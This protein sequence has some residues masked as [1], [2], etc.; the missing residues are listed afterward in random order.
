MKSGVCIVCSKPFKSS[1]Y[2]FLMKKTDFPD[3][4]SGCRLANRDRMRRALEGRAPD[5]DDEFISK[6]LND[7]KFARPQKTFVELFGD[8]DKNFPSLPPQTDDKQ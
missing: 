8:A 7:A 3:K 1:A 4:C 6:R 5:S 2:W